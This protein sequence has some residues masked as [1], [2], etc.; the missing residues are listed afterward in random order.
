MRVQRPPTLLLV[1]S[2]S[3][4]VTAFSKPL[5]VPEHCQNYSGCMLRA[6]IKTA[7]AG[8]Y[9]NFRIDVPSAESTGTQSVSVDRESTSTHDGLTEHVTSV[10]L[11]DVGYSV[12]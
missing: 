1:F 10:N 7:Q 12:N 2:L 11:F 3:F 9:T 4:L 8:L 6:C 5:Y